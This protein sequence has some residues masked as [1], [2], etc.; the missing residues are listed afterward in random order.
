M[1]NKIRGKNVLVQVKIGEEYYP[2]ACFQN[3]ELT[4]STSFIEVV[5]TD[6]ND[7][8]SA[9]FVPEKNSYT[10]SAGGLSTLDGAKISMP[11]LREFQENQIELFI[12][13]NLD[14]KIFEGFFYIAS[15]SDSVQFDNEQQ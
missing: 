10:G 15:V 7:G 13:F 9:A 6:N 3:L 8:L 2:I 4:T 14:G 5:N 1:S 11:T 12:R